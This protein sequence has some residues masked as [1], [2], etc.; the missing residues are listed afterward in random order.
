[1][2]NSAQ[3]VF[4][5]S[6][7]T[8]FSTRNQAPVLFAIASARLSAGAFGLVAGAEAHSTAPDEFIAVKVI[9]KGFQISNE[10]V[11]VATADQTAVDDVWGSSSPRPPTIQLLI[12]DINNLLTPSPD[13]SSLGGPTNM[14]SWEADGT[15]EQYTPSGPSLAANPG[16]GTRALIVK[17]TVRRFQITFVDALVGVVVPIER[18]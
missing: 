2:G 18:V 5:G 9:P 13:P 14:T 7:F 4:T 15:N 12:Q 6:D 17:I 1:M 11:T 16:N 3:L 10:A 8:D